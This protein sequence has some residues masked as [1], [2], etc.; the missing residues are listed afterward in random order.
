MNVLRQV[1][2]GFLMA[3]PVL[4]GGQ[5][6]APGEDGRIQLVVVVTDKTGKPVPGLEAKDFTVK[7]TGRAVKISSFH[8]LDGSLAGA[9]PTKVV[10]VLDA[11]NMGFTQAAFAR[12]EMVKYLRQNG[13]HLAYPVSIYLFGNQGTEMH[14][15]VSTDGNA[16]ADGLAKADTQLRSVASS[17]GEYGAV[18]RFSQSIKTLV[19]IVGYEADQPGR[20]LVIWAGAGWPMLD[21]R[22]LQMSDKAQKQIFDQLVEM[23]NWTR[24]GQVALYS[25]SAGALDHG[26][27]QYKEFLKGVKSV[28]KMNPS[29]LALKVLATESGGNVLGPDN[30]LAGQIATAVEDAKTYY[31]ISFD[32]PGGDKVNEYHELK[33]EVSRPGVTVRTSSGY[34]SR[35]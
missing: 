26:M 22:T 35:P 15:P 2:C 14:P 29:N 34:Y 23:T 19:S 9:P 17:R 5:D 7:D 4:L 16:L 25:I 12:T 6:A 18:D 27:S 28:E 1:C 30:D 13:G 31:T 11:V 32:P 21:W 8:A 33:V 24:E 10:L 20:K 3:V